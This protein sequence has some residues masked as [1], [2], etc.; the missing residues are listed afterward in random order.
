MKY[1]EKCGSELMD[2]AVIC[3]NC[4]CPTKENKKEGK[5]LGVCAIVFGVLGGWLG[6]VLGIIGLSIYKERPNRTNSLIG[7]IFSC[8]WSVIWIVLKAVL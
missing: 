8:I 4:G 7:L 6:L 1:C 3:P 2:E 5:A